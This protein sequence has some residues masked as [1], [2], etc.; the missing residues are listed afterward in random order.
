MA[1]GR[2]IAAAMG[3]ALAG[4]VAWAMAIG[5][6]LPERVAKAD[7]IGVV[8]IRSVWL[9]GAEEPGRNADARVLDVIKGER[10]PSHVII[11]F[12][13]GLGCPKELFERG[14]VYL[15]FLRE[16]PDGGY[17]ALNFGQGRFEVRDDLIDYWGRKEVVRLDEAKADIERLMAR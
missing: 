10:I 3:G 9:S 5:M 17:S 7:F 14:A 11:S 1:L 12:D 2:G 13:D 15:V 4:S 8:E 16:D 6:P